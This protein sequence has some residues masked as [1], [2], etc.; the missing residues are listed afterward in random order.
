MS[1][2]PS[3]SAIQFISNRYF[4]FSLASLFCFAALALA[5]VWLFD[6]GSA[7]GTSTPATQPGPQKSAAAPDQLKASAAAKAALDRLRLQATTPLKS[8]VSRETGHYSFVRATS[9]GV[10]AVDNTSASPESRALAFLAQHGALVGMNS[11]ER[12]S[13]AS[14]SAAADTGSVMRVDKVSKDSIG[15]SHVRLNQHYRGLPVFGAQLIVHMNSRGVTALNGNFVPEIKINTTPR[16]SEAAARSI[17][18]RQSDEGAALD[19]VSTQLSIYRQGLLEGYVGQNVLAYNVEVTD[20]KGGNAQI[21]IDAVKGTMLNRIPLTHKALN[22]TVYSPMYDPNNPDLFVLRRE[23]EPALPGPTPGTTGANPRDNLYEFSGQVY[24]IFASAFGRD[25][26]DGAGHKMATVLLVS[27]N[28][29]VPCPN[30][31]WNGIST[32]YCPDFDADDVVAHEWGHAYT[33]YT[34][35]LI[36]SYQA[37]G[38][39][40]AYSDIF[41]E[42]LDLLNGLDAEG[43]S[44]NS[45]PM[46]NGQRWQVGDDVPTINAEALGILRDMWDPTRYGDPDK[47]S[48]ANYDCAADAVHTT[49]GVP[50]HAFA[51][52]V[53]GKTF[54][55]QTVE[56]IGFTRA[57]HI[58]YRAMTVY[59]IPSSNFAMHDQSLQASC[60]DLIGQP[61]NAISTTSTGQALSG[62]VITAGTCQQV[63]KAML[64]VEMSA[65]VATRC[66]YQPILDKNPPQS[67]AGSTS[68]FSENW[69]TGT[70]GWT[71]TSTGVTADWNDS[72]RNLRDFT[73]D[74]SLPE[75]RS[76][77]AI[78]AKNIPLGEDGGGTCAAGGDYSGQFT[79]DGP[80]ITIPSGGETLKLSFDQ[81]VA[82]EATFDG[83]QVEI[84][85]NGGAYQ[86]VPQDQYEY[87]A[88]N[89]ALA[90][91]ADGNTNPNAGEFAWQGTDEGTFAGSWG[92]T[93]VNLSTLTNPGDKVRLRFTFSQDGCNGIDGW[94]V[95]NVNV[96]VC[97][98]LEA[99]VLSL[100]NDYT[101]PDSDGTYTLNWMRPT[102]A[103]G[104]DTIQTSTQSCAPLLFDDAES[105]LGQWTVTTVGS[106]TPGFA[107]EAVANDKPQHSGTTFRA[108]GLNTVVD[109]ASLLTYNSPITIPASGPTLLT[110]SDWNVNEGDDAMVVEIS[111]D[112]VNWTSVYLDSRSELL[113]DGAAAFATQPLFDRTVDLTPYAGQTIRLRFRYQMGAEDRPGSVPLGWYLDDIAI[114]NDSWSNV[115]TTSNTSHTVTNAA[116]GTRCY[117]VNTKYPIQ[118]QVVDGPFS[119]IVS[120]TVARAVNPP[121]VAIGSPSEGATFSSGANITI[122]ASANDSDGNVTKVEFFQNGNKVGEDTTGPDY[123]VTWNNVPAGSYTLTAMAT[124][125]DSASTTSDPVHITVT[126]A[127]SAEC[128]ED[129]DPRLAYTNGWHKGNDP[130]ASAGHFRYNTGKDSNHSVGLDFTVP[131]GKVG[132][133]DYY[134]AR[135]TKKGLADVYLDGV[136]KTTINYQGQVGSMQHPEFSPAYVVSYGG[137]TAG[138][139]RIELR[140]LRDVVFIDRFCIESASSNS[141]PAA[142]PG[143]TTNQSQTVGGG[144]SSSSNYA[145]QPGAQEISIVAESNVAIPFQLVLINPSGLT[146]QTVSASSGLATINAPVNSQGLYVIKVVNL[147]V[148]PVQLTTVATPLVRR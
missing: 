67:C 20:G 54:N 9:N 23:G 14:E 50:N 17:A 11:A 39:N 33:Q 37:G 1:S 104:P 142:G 105:G 44:N 42:T 70:D 25:S 127:P 48:S 85:V 47:V 119:N 79:I 129:D 88:P 32:N 82:T 36:Y 52:L 63:A 107:W 108:R 35:G 106:N 65:D 68:V 80:E 73:I 90:A 28:P 4:R 13:A 61:L 101:E 136:F 22:R 100:G 115:T 27:T 21:W 19:V 29:N 16:I 8:Q 40:E 43:G 131:A 130:N 117:R 122:I 113:P 109:A 102:G 58:Y 120:A 46:P 91:T 3:R 49:S 141:Q 148:G 64:A 83:G 133:V 111:T 121:S 2:L 71:L 45:Q 41:G 84:S 26:Y 95:D 6:L 134:F 103:V 138:N 126:E 132:K 143:N 145:M 112:N 53:D 78:Y 60:Q 86:L 7:A 38:L 93:I 118:G 75:G 76:G 15:S 18:A 56:A 146:V 123:R 5:S 99:P 59:Q 98:T 87:N 124:D 137:L 92:T 10:L 30:A 116:N 89:A 97:P 125:N 62:E 57:L 24:N 94:Y 96:F 139:H 114:R 34:H 66:N 74:S 144:N 128:I 72:T 31:Y 77:S 135:S 81:Y 12:K 140:N 110:F 51:M 55:G 69:E 147:S